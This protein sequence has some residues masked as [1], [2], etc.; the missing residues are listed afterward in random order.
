MSPQSTNWAMMD[1]MTETPELIQVRRN[2][3][4]GLDE[5]NNPDFLHLVFNKF[6]TLFSTG[7]IRNKE[8][9]PDREM[10]RK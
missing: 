9:I 5:P 7:S 4:F 8:K 1:V 3:L 10:S 6:K 2:D